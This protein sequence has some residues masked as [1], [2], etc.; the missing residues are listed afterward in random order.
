MDYLANAHTVYLKHILDNLRRDKV[1]VDLFV[2]VS[3]DYIDTE[4]ES[5]VNYNFVDKGL[6]TMTDRLLGTAAS[7]PDFPIGQFVHINASV[8]A[9]PSLHI[10]VENDIITGAITLRGQPCNFRIPTQC[11]AGF[12]TQTIE[13]SFNPNL[14]TKF[15]IES[16][17]AGPKV[18]ERP[19]RPTLTV[20]K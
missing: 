19:K 3:T 11:I 4:T 17:N 16:I 10:D 7:G 18:E 8:N 5:P 6:M 14:Y 12:R 20:V 1:R 9:C 15:L 13:H 2:Y